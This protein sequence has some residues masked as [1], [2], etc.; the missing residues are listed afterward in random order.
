LTVMVTFVMDA[1]AASVAGVKVA[2]AP[3]GRPLAAKVTVYRNVVAT[4]GCTWS[5]YTTVVP[6]RTVTI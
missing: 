6:G 1:P 4:W 2:V 3:A 5:V